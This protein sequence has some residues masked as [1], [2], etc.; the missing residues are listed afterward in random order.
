MIQVRRIGAV[1]AVLA[2]LIV[3]FNV[4][5][6]SAQESQESGGNALRISPL[7]P[8]LT[9]ERG[10]AETVEIEITNLSNVDIIAKV[11]LNDFEA[12]GNTGNPK[13]IVD[14]NTP[15]NAN[16]L[17]DY[18]IG[19]EDQELK[20]GETK[21]VQ[22]TVQIP[23]QASPGAYYGAVRFTS[24]PK[25][26]N[27][28]DGFQ[29]ALNA[30]VSSLLLVEVPGEINEKIE[31][32]TVKAYIDDKAGSLFVKR[33]NKVGIEIKNLGN[34]FSKPFGKVE[35]KNMFGKVVHSYELNDTVPQ[36]GNI[37]P[38][39]SRLFKD[40]LSGIKF[41]GKYTISSGISYGRGG[42][43]LYV[44]GSF[45]FLPLWF[46]LAIILLV[47]AIFG[48]GYFMYRRYISQPVSRRR[49]H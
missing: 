31:I 41:P 47:G 39:S 1:F 11:F 5:L 28:D 30:S 29:V 46:I 12:D 42:E 45:W 22:V 23:E 15:R 20:A 14:Q 48:S 8:E 26:T 32:S 21:G 7:R 19:L 10:K 34:S 16:S 9:I 44:T 35:I 13:L 36:R 24:T 33:P 40:D 37:L 2:L 4:N 18:I 49:R 6:I 27:N 43:I 25:D 38:N 17:A 3:P